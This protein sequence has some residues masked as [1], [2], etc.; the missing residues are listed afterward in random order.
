MAS[1]GGSGMKRRSVKD[2]VQWQTEQAEQ[3]ILSHEKKP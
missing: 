3:L 1:S 2:N